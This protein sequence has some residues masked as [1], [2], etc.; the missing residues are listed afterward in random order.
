MKSNRADSTCESHC[1]VNE[2]SNL[3][4]EHLHGCY[5]PLFRRSFSR[6]SNK[7]YGRKLYLNFG[8]IYQMSRCHSV[9]DWSLPSI[10]KF[11]VCHPEVFNTYMN[12]Q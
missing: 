5:L 12:I 7:Y 9:K 3:L 1:N 2:D 6:P 10:L 8:N 4:E 11:N